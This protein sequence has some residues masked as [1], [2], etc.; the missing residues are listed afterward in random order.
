MSCECEKGHKSIV[1][2]ACPCHPSIMVGPM[3]ILTYQHG[4]YWLEED[5]GEGAQVNEGFLA[6]KLRLILKDV[7]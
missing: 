3:L 7:M 1:P 6:E 5:G 2:C 4:G